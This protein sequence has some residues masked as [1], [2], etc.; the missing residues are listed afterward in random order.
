MEACAGST[1]LVCTIVIDCDIRSTK[2]IRIRFAHWI[3]SLK[4]INPCSGTN[5][6]GAG[7]MV[8]V[9]HDKSRCGGGLRTMLVTVQLAALENQKS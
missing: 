1:Y 2:E 7:R 9:V 5:V 8:R 4:I 6:S 3:A